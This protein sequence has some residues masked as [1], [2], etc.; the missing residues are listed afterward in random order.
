MN[1]TLKRC[2]NAAA[3]TAVAFAALVTVSGTAQAK[4]GVANLR[5]GATGQGVRCV[6]LAIQ[7]AGMGTV[8]DLVTVDGVWG[9]RTQDGV[10]EFQEH[11]GIRADGVVGPVT[12]QYMYE[13]LRD[14]LYH[15]KCYNY[16]PTG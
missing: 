3:A 15:Q 7:E 2:V 16:L 9:P 13:L 5:Y 4:P 10:I 14:D 8:S 11:H 1:R 6:Q 12:G